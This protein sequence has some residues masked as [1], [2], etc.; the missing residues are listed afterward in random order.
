MPRM[1]HVTTNHTNRAGFHGPTIR[2]SEDTMALV[3][4]E[5]QYVEDVHGIRRLIRKAAQVPV[6]MFNLDDVNTEEA[7]IRT[8]A[9]PVVDEDASP[10]AGTAGEPDAGLST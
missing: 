8:L 9:R 1:N 3:A 10:A 4:K 5:D 6:G 7:D 2:T